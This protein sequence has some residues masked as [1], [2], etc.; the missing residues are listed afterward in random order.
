MISV[1]EQ[2]R[3]L[4]RGVVDFYV[5][6]ELKSKLRRA[7]KENRPL[8]VKTGFDPT[9]PD[10]H[11]GHTVLLYKMR[12]F[13]EL[14]HTVIFLIGD[15]TSLIG[16]PTGKNV[17]RPPM[18][19]EEILENAETYK[20]Q[21]F[22][23]LDKDKTEVRFNSEWMDELP[24]TE[25][26]RLAASYNVARMFE[27]DDFRTRFK[28]GRSI[29]IH[30]FLY[31]LV[32]AYDSVALEADVELGGHDQIFNLLVGRDIQKTYGQEPQVVMTV[33]LLE[34]TDGV[35]KMSKSLNNYIGID[36]APRDIYGKTMSI[37]DDMMWKYFELCSS[38]SLEEI[39][40]LKAEVEKGRNPMEVKM[41]LA[42]E[43]VVRYQGEARLEEARAAFRKPQIEAEDIELAIE[44]ES[45]GIGKLLATLGFVKS[46]SEGRRMVK[47]GAVKIDG[48]KIQ[49]QDLELKK[50]FKGL[51]G[52]GKRKFA[53]VSL[54]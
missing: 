31:P 23:I 46:N 51:I 5:E 35:H 9:A 39:A 29:C 37:S 28:E 4:K 17:T 6:E 10:L 53:Q 21:V 15:F 26:I 30:E 7:V 50:G 40:S 44:D 22:K 54:I 1:D 52:C 20:Q 8:R 45:I 24:S 12:Q 16:D 47:Q 42:E 2:L 34:G 32:Q 43:F 49:D 25:M 18:T 36:E 13:Q 11:L 19:R 14:G 48:E 38:R 41:L 27:R 33:P 3:R